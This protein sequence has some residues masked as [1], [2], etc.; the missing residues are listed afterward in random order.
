MYWFRDQK[1]PG[2]S[3]GCLMVLGQTKK[4]IILVLSYIIAFYRDLKLKFFR[5]K[6]ACNSGSWSQNV[7]NF[8]QKIQFLQNISYIHC[9]SSYK[10][11]E[12]SQSYSSFILTMFSVFV[13]IF[14]CT[15]QVSYSSLYK[16]DQFYRTPN[17]WI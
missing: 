9:I 11:P 1:K 13:L 7:W 6:K 12:D 16:L 5:G 10:I 14:L 15:L 17:I 3:G 4:I 8:V 2:Q